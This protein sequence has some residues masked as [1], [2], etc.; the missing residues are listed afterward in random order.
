MTTNCATTMRGCASRM[1][2]YFGMRLLA[3]M[4]SHHLSRHQLLHATGS[5]AM[6][7]TALEFDRTCSVQVPRRFFAPH[8]PITGARTRTSECLESVFELASW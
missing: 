1:H 8:I 3:H 5:P 7:S 4:R 2:N 6:V